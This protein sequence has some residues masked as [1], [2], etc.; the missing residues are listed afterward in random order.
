MNKEIIEIGIF[1]TGAGLLALL[2]MHVMIRLG[3]F[4]CTLLGLAV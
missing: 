2:T 4:I 1:S 3:C